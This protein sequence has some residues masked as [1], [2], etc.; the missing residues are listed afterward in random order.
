MFCKAITEYWLIFRENGLEA[1]ASLN[2]KGFDVVVI[3]LEILEL[4][5][6]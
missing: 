5:E 4:R 2:E 6:N 1:T 3:K